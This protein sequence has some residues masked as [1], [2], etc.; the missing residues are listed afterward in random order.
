MTAKYLPK[1]KTSVLLR[2]TTQ[3]CAASS[4]CQEGQKG[5]IKKGM[6]KP[7]CVRDMLIILIGVMVSWAYTNVKM[8]HTVHLC[9]VCHV[10]IIPQ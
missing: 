2:D 5:C 6:R 4:E 1:I 7:L 9:E 8:Y 3:K 10:S